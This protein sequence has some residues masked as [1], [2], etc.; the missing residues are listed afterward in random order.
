[1]SKLTFQLPESLHRSIQ[2]L[3]EREGYSIE[4]F[5]AIAAAEKMAALRTLDYLRREAAAG[6]REDFDRFLAAVPNQEP[7]ATDR[8]PE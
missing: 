8:M 7:V 3:A 5:L 4:Q 6:R 2:A 1:M